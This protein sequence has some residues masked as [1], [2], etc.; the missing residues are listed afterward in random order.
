MSALERRLTGEDEGA[1]DR[2]A[3]PMHPPMHCTWGPTE[4]CTRS[5]RITSLGPGGCF[6]R[7]KAEAVESQP[8]YVNCW[9]PTERWLTLRARVKYRLPKVGFGLS[10]V[11][12]S[13]AEREMLSSLLEF[14]D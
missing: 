14:Y 7:T 12:L 8:L 1:A 9:L 3:R 2:L 10:F 4:D 11:G 6:V 13:E 5:G